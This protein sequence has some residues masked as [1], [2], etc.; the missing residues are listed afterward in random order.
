[1]SASFA[2]VGLHL[3]FR[4]Q[5]MPLAA[6]RQVARDVAGVGMNTLLIEWEGSYPFQEH[7]IISNEFAYTREEVES[8][9]E[10][11]C[12][13]G[14]EVV[15][16]QQ[17][18][19]HVEYILR[20][21]R[22]V[23]LREN[24]KDLCQLCPGKR[25]EALEVFR[26]IFADISAMHPSPYLHIGGDETYLLGQCPACQKRAQKVGKSR[27]Y[28][29]YFKEVAREVIK[30]G[31]RPIMWADML[32]KYPEAAAQM[33]KGTVFMDWNYGWDVNHF[34]DLSK[35]RADGFEFWGA[36]ALRAHPDNHSLIT[37]RTHFENLRDFVPFAR[38]SGYQGLILTSWSTSGVYGYEWERPGEAKK[39]FPMRRV[40][41][42]AGFRILFDA[43]REAVGSHEALDPAKFV[44]AYARERFGLTAL[45][46]GRL[47]QALTAEAE[48]LAPG[49]AVAPVLE[50]AVKAQGMLA[51]MRPVRNR[52]EFAHLRLISDLRVHDLR[53]KE[54]EARAQSKWFDSSRAGEVADELDG[55]LK[56][57][58]VLDARFR[59]LNRKGLY[60]VELEE[61]IAYRRRKFRELHARVTRAGRG[62]GVILTPSRRFSF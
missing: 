24:S 51:A 5:T 47:W 16:L 18:F 17:C 50:K 25:T 23:H 19:G 8:F 61:E 35:L 46:G 40:Y 21:E 58:D 13:F 14:V 49:Q 41:P 27:L 10:E 15:P 38:E 11:C 44:K 33:P 31:K 29:D 20:H 57:G 53:F 39:L 54:I 34:G 30:L 60:P 28:T 3:D 7:A 42:F 62:K 26:E 1:M 56:D 6:L 48:V 45:E 59:K 36:P 12:G 37:W 52:E 55:L 2:K 22:Y 9:I 43:F 32:L 4:V